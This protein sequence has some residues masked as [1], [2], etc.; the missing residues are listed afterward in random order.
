M[1]TKI[2]CHVIFYAIMSLIFKI[3]LILHDIISEFIKLFSL[4]GS[5]ALL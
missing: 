5:K 2:L 3:A 4:K 1:I